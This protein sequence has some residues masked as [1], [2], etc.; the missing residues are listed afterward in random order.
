MYF[1]VSVELAL[2]RQKRKRRK[3]RKEKQ[4]KSKGQDVPGL[5]EAKALSKIQEES[6]PKITFATAEDWLIE[7]IYQISIKDDSQHNKKM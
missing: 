1:K 7:V 2:V 3:I 4:S 6:R 5:I